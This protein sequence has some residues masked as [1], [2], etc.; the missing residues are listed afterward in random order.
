MMRLSYETHRLKSEAAV[1]LERF[2]SHTLCELFEGLL[3]FCA[4]VFN[5][6]ADAEIFLVAAVPAASDARY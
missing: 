2:L 6:Y 5:I 1:I 3:A 4:V